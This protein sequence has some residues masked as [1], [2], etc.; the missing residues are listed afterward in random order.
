MEASL[1]FSAAAAIAILME[2]CE[3]FPYPDIFLLMIEDL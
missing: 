3:A 2:S 1:I